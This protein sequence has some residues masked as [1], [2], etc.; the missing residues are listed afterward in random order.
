MQENSYEN[1]YYHPESKNQISPEFIEN[2]VDMQFDQ[3]DF[4][5]GVFRLKEEG[6]KDMNKIAYEEGEMIVRQQNKETE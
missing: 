4:F 5:E 1:Q 3:F 2:V 6:A